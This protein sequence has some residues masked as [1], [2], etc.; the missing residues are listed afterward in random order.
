V[1]AFLSLGVFLL[2]G[3]LFVNN[4][5]SIP[6][7]GHGCQHNSLPR[8]IERIPPSRLKKS[9]NFNVYAVYATDGKLFFWLRYC[10]EKAFL[11]KALE[12]MSGEQIIPAFSNARL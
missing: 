4:L 5:L 9:G 8:S 3:L 1:T 7:V 11:V 6:L 10:L 2:W 12:G